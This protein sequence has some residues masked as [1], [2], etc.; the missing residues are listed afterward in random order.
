MNKNRAKDKISQKINLAN[1]NASEEKEKSGNGLFK[2]IQIRN[3]KMSEDNIRR[4]GQAPGGPTST[5]AKLRW[6]TWGKGFVNI[7]TQSFGG[8][9]GK[10]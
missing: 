2:N 3:N 1:S 8:V 10:K 4:A 5:H 7:A 6:G 9:R